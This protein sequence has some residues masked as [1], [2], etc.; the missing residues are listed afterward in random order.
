MKTILDRAKGSPLD[1][2]SGP[3]DDADI[4]ALL[5]PHAQQFRTLDFVTGYWSDIQ[6]FSEAVSGPLPLLHTLKVHAVE[7]DMMGPET[8][9]PSS[10]P[11]FSGAVNLKKFVLLSEG[12]PFLNR[13]AFPNL[14]T[15]GLTAMQENDQFPVSQ[16]LSFLEATPTLRTVHIEIVGE[17]SF[18]CV[19]PDRVIVLPNVEE[20]TLTEDEYGYNIATH[21]SCPS[22]SHTSLVYVQ[23]PGHEMPQEVFPTSVPWNAIASRYT[24]KPIDGVL[25][26]MSTVRSG[27]SC[28]LS[29]LSPGPATLKLGYRMIVKDEDD[30]D[31]DIDMDLGEA[32]HKV[33]SDASKAIRNHPLLA[34][35]KRL[36]I[37]DRP[38]HPIFDLLGRIAKEVGELFK[39]LGP[40]E[41][42][43]LN[44]FDLRPYLAP[45]LDPPP[46]QYVKQPDAFPSIKELTIAGPEP[47]REDCC[48]AVVEFAKSQHTLNVPFE[49]VIFHMKDPPLAM[50]ERLEPW[51][52]IVCFLEMITTGED[53]NLV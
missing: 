27:L 40:L 46:F 51:V 5:S 52:G 30:E 7:Y 42:L 3:L 38:T 34:N 35:V 14:T 11:L 19:P 36:R 39:S 1:I 8:T 4:M 24:M 21:I 12:L 28:S 49:R 43:T 20:F 31:I 9:N 32:Y 18:E 17:M 16:L 48:A 13:F 25:L 23:P 2:R 47:L 22:A 29:F 26:M 37:L 10:A 53:Q 33:F 41:E 50:G 15:F 6:E 45:F 44:V